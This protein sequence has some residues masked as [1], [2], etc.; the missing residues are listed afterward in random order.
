MFVFLKRTLAVLVLVALG[1][2]EV[3]VLNWNLIL[4]NVGHI[5]VR[6]APL[7]H[8]DAILVLGGN[9]DLR[10]PRAAELF[11]GGY[12]S[13]LLVPH[14]PGAHSMSVRTIDLLHKLGISDDRI[15]M[16]GRPEGVASTAD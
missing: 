15:Q 3:T 14:E 2:C 6:S 7:E 10:L 8:A 5:L 11:R 1:L 16:I 12:A 9:P 13:L 4:C